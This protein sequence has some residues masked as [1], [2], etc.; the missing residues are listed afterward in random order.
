MVYASVELVFS[1]EIL[2]EAIEQTIVNIHCPAAIQANEVMM[3]MNT[4]NLI[5]DAIFRHICLG[6]NP[7]IFQPLEDA[8]NCRF[9][10]DLALMLLLDVITNSIDRHMGVRVSQGIQHQFPLDG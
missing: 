1:L 10:N 8:V 4:H 9:W 3:G 2:A 5:D 6:D 7:H